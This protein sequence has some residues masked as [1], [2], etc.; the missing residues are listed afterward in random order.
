MEIWTQ[1]P[2]T[3]RQGTCELDS[4]SV[5]VGWRVL[6]RKIV[7]IVLFE[8]LIANSGSQGDGDGD[9]Q[10][11]PVHKEVRSY[12]VSFDT[13]TDPFARVDEISRHV[14]QVVQKNCQGFIVKATRAWTRNAG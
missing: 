7:V 2:R 6:C 14:F 1:G 4:D 13:R 8:F 9:V 11:D 3:A 10:D 5:V 12:L